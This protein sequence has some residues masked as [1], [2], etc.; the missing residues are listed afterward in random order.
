MSLIRNVGLN[1][2]RIGGIEILKLMGANIEIINMKN[3]WPRKS[4]GH[5]SLF[6]KFKRY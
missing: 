5:K 2:F 4:W 1:K 3:F 6:I